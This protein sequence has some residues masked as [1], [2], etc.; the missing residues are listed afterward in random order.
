MQYET[1]SCSLKTWRQSA[2]LRSIRFGNASSDSSGCSTSHVTLSYA[3]WSSVR[4]LVI[5]AC[6]IRGQ[7]T[8]LGGAISGLGDR[9]TTRLV[10]FLGVAS[11][12]VFQGVVRGALRP[13]ESVETLLDTTKELQKFYWLRPVEVTQRGVHI[14][15]APHDRTDPLKFGIVQVGA[16]VFRR[17]DIKETT[18]LHCTHTVDW[19]CN[20][21]TPAT[22]L[23]GE[24]DGRP[25]LW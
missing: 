23:V 2:A 1:S 20:P 9:L 16:N 21:S 13:P 15:D 12:Q 14:F 3:R 7:V 11:E 6:T 24:Y 8:S 5:I 10:K 22:G 4:H 19:V 18:S 25:V 17:Y